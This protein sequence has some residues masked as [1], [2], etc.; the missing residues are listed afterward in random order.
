MGC[1]GA[2]EVWGPWARAHRA[3]WIRRPWRYGW[4]LVKFSPVTGIASLQ[5]PRWGW[6]PANIWLNFT[7]PETTMI[8][9]PTLET[10]RSYLYSSGQNIPQRVGQTDR[11]AGWT[12]SPWL[13]QRSMHC[14]Q[15]GRAVIIAC[16]TINA[17][18]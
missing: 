13:L 14:E 2:P 7:S 3:H 6:P 12:V 15:C 4:L 5:R 11:Q 9:L 1:L 16:R 10:A 8:V 18:S 17:Y